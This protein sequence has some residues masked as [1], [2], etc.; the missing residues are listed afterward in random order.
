MIPNV[1]SLVPSEKTGMRRERPKR[2][3]ILDIVL[4]EPKTML[5]RSGITVML[6]TNSVETEI[7]TAIIGTA[8]TMLCRSFAF[9][10]FAIPF[11]AFLY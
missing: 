5:A 4:N 11:G 9:R 6:G 10:N 2:K 8:T 7:I 3:S 1:R